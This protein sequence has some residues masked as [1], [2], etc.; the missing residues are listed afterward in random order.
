M[1]IW[2]RKFT[3]QKIKK[4]YEDQNTKNKAVQAKTPKIARPD[5]KPSFKT[6]ASSK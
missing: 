2:L 5:I 3:F 1:P 4:F 6:K